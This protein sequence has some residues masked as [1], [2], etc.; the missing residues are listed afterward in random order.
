MTAL[1]TLQSSTAQGVSLASPPA[2]ADNARRWQNQRSLEYSMRD[3]MWFSI[4]SGAGETY[5]SAFA[6]FLKATSEQ[7]ALLASVPPLIGS[8]MQL[9]SA[10]LGG[11][12]TSRKALII[13]GACAQGF[14][15]FPLVL[16][17][18]LW[19]AYAVP[20]LI[21]CTVLYHAFGSL[22]T[23]QWSSLMRDLVPEERRGRYFGHR[24]R[25]ISLVTFIALV[26]AGGVLALFNRGEAT[27]AGFVV[28]FAVATIARFVSVYYLAL[29]Q[30]PQRATRTEP[31]AIFAGMWRSLKFLRGSNFL[32]FS[33]FFA[34]MQAAVAI[35]S[36][37]F[38]V[39]MLR[40]LQYSYLQFM[41]ATAITVVAQF[42]TLNVWG[43]ISDA[44]GNRLVLV[45]TGWMIPVVPALWLFSGN[46]WYLMIVQAFGGLVWAGFSLSAGNFLY[47][48]RPGPRLARDMAVH[49]VLA[50]IGVFTGAIL[51]G[52]LASRLPPGGLV[53]AG[54]SLHWEFVLLA[55]IGIS[56]VARLLVASIFLPRLREVRQVRAVSFSALVF[57]VTRVHA[58]SGMMF[59][60]V[61]ARGRTR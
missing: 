41:A 35:A 37:F 42:L 30:D 28:V 3:G 10:W 19:P 22:I 53:F 31:T 51:G 27:L 8:G 46:F 47:D 25:I 33:I 48:L 43:R 17:P 1:S 38:T 56:A 40:D 60:I 32:H 54:V 34:C 59:D 2:G 45:V 13:A 18:L 52:Y 5:L 15:W 14:I 50:S 21:G 16:L 9:V 20:L 26:W 57:R 11:R 44:F 61:G 7:I 49:N 4:M 23:P 36:P 39:Y 12:G 24:T 29:M 6:L 55:V 58:L